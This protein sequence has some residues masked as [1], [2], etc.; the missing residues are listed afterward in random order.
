[1]AR[2]KRSGSSPNAAAMGGSAVAITVESTFCMNSAQATM[3]GTIVWRD[4]AG[5][6]VQSNRSCVLRLR[7]CG[8]SLRMRGKENS[9]S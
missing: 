2:F 6:R 7:P 8:A 9:S 4:S 1:M 3:S 5:M